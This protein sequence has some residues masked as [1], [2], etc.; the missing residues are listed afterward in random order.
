MEQPIDGII[1]NYNEGGD[2]LAVCSII[3]HA[4]N[5]PMWYERTP[6]MHGLKL[7][8]E[9]D[10]EM[11]KNAKNVYKVSRYTKEV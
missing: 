11:I 5:L 1:C 7:S 8:I 6:K 10:L 2:V 9:G 4:L 3:A